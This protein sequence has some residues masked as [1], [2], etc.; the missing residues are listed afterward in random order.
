MSRTLASLALSEGAH[1]R[2]ALRA[3]DAGGWSAPWGRARHQAGQW[4]Q[5][6]PRRLRRIISPSV[7]NVIFVISSPFVISD[8]GCESLLFVRAKLATVACYR[9]TWFGPMLRRVDFLL[10][11]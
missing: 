5:P 7:A 11:I 2:S 1:R 6:V 10:D 3:R 4:L 8:V 9:V